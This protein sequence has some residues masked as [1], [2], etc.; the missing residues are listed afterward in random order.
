MNGDSSSFEWN[1]AER[2]ACGDCRALEGQLHQGGCDVE[3][4][5]FCLGQLISCGCCYRHFYPD[6]DDALV[7]DLETQYAEALK[8][9]FP[10]RKEFHGLPE[11]VYREGLPPHQGAEWDRLLEAKGRVPYFVQPNLCVRCGELWPEMFGADDWKTLMPADVR[12]EMLCRACYELAKSFVLLGRREQG[13]Q[14]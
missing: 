8:A 10:N 12:G 5:P 14:S 1:P 6:Y 9:G 3:R 4:C 7:H 13:Q 11:A 2:H